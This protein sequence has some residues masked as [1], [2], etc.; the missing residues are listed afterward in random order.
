MRPPPL[1][2]VSDHGRASG[3]LLVARGPREREECA[4]ECRASEVRETVRAREEGGPRPARDE[5]IDV[6][7]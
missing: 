6:R 5:M 1:M 4:V 2:R 7:M 3:G